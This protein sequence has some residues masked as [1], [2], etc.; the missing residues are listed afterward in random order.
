MA[1]K[2]KILRKTGLD[3][4]APDEA[5]AELQAGR[6]SLIPGTE[7][8]I[9]GPDNGV[10]YIPAERAPKALVD[11]FRFATSPE[12]ARHEAAKRP[13]LA[14]TENLVNEGL[15]IPGIGHAAERLFGADPEDLAARAETGAGVVGRVV[16]FGAGLLGPGLLKG[17]ATGLK[18]LVPGV[19]A[20]GAERAVREAAE[21]ALGRRIESEVARKAIAGGLGSAAVGAGI[22]VGGVIDEAALGNP[23]ISVQDLALGAGLGALVGGAL[24]GGLS[25]WVARKTVKGRVPNADLAAAL[26]AEG[27]DEAAEAV[28]GKWYKQPHIWA[29]RHIHGQE[30]A[31]DLAKVYGPGARRLIGQEE[32]A[33]TEATEQLSKLIDDMEATHRDPRGISRDQGPVRDAI[34]AKVPASYANQAFDEGRDLLVGV[35]A[36]ITD[37]VDGA[38]QYG[39]SPQAMVN[40]LNPA[41]DLTEQALRRLNKLEVLT[42]PG[43]LPLPE[44]VKAPGKHRKGGK[45]VKAPLELKVTPT[46]LTP[47]PRVLPAE[48]GQ[49]AFREVEHVY[50]GLVALAKKLKGTT[51]E[52]PGLD[53][54]I[55]SLASSLGDDT[56]WG[57]AGRLYKDYIQAASDTEVAHA[58]V[59]K[60]FRPDSAG[61]MDRG[62]VRA[63]L[64]DIDR[65][66][67]D[68]RLDAINRWLES[69]RRFAEASEKVF[70]DSRDLVNRVRTQQAQH[71]KVWKRLRNDVGALNALQRLHSLNRGLSM[72]GM[73]LARFAAPAV[74]ATIGGQISEY[75]GIP[76]GTVAGGLIGHALANPG[77]AAAQLS[78]LANF[79][80]RTARAFT[81]G[82]DSM[83][84]VHTPQ[85]AWPM[86]Q[87]VTKATIDM[88]DGDTAEAR[89]RAFD[90]RANEIATLAEP[91]A[92]A[93]HIEPQMADMDAL[94]GHQQAT[95][96]KASQVLAYLAGRIPEP[97]HLPPSGALALITG[98][99]APGRPSD[100]KIREFAEVDRIAQDPSYFLE[101]VDK[102][103]VRAIHMEALQ[104]LYPALDQ[105]LR[106]QL[107]TT[108]PRAKNIKPAHKRSIQAIMGTDV[109]SPQQATIR[110]GVFEQ[111]A[112]PPQGASSTQNQPSAGAA[113]AS[114]TDSLTYGAP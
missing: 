91:G 105:R 73:G 27:D 75:T 17:T 24:G 67:S 83:L 109:I 18:H 92:L 110:A 20:E 23:D 63:T 99:T 29:T 36:H 78:A 50:R 112:A 14:F 106:N 61:R 94:P 32:R 80:E 42:D 89:R 19:A 48:A 107:V 68:G 31:E 100:R 95:A 5:Q 51:D 71:Q 10:A 3:E 7:I 54:L 56:M 69:Q 96:Y 1:R 104:E 98:Q 21:R 88:L 43:K 86:K 62:A 108:L 6:A 26:R 4:V 22:G 58:E 81:A 35:R 44:M 34:A 33:R 74:G 28:T 111:P 2:V 93:R 85:Y 52:A 66:K 37:L 16:G 53:P 70:P 77:R 72:G 55:D 25:A 102:G 82:L 11:G 64:N 49:A 101:L 46:E 60:Y 57:P 39:K 41:L 40:A 113:V 76:G 9:V 65:I 30:A 59:Q 90:Q 38:A 8:A 12:I 87:A 45:F 13:G 47:T 15:P 97:E 114:E 84:G 79:K 103:M